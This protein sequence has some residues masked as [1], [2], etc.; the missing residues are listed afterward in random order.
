[1]KQDFGK[2]SLAAHKKLRG[3]I[4]VR[5]KAPVRNKKDL[6]LYYTPGVGTVASHVA[7][8][9]ED[10]GKMTSRGNM[11]AVVSDGSAVLG[12]GNI[13]PYGALPVMEG[14]AILFKTFAGIDAFPIVLNTQDP[15]RIVETV[16]ALE[17][18]FGAINLEDIAA[19][20]CFEIERRLKEEMNI[21]VMHDDQH[22]TAMV[23]LAGL[24]NA[25]KVRGG[26]KES[27]RIVVNG[28]GAAGLAITDLLLKY[29]F[30]HIVVSDSQGAIYRGR[31]GLN[32][33]KTRLAELTNT[34]CHIDQ[35]DPR[36]AVGDLGESL[37]GADVFIGVSRAGALKPAMVRLMNPKPIIF[38]MANPVPEIM[39]DE[40][41]K[42]GAYVVATG[43]SDFPNQINNSLGFPGIF[44]G[45][46]D[47][48]VKQ[49][50]DEMLV[51]AAVKLAALV[52]KPTPNMIIPDPFD[53]RVVKAVASAIR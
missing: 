45:A 38:A 43:R 35:N 41:K 10:A 12:L 17:P 25:L 13:G 42:A 2:L 15:D 52:K 4:E 53:K 51:K 31:E 48:G 47:N 3:K 18:S 39:P 34:V 14:K 30:K 28:A 8:R 32:G 40:A 24:I 50:T 16:K 29:G 37:K 22:G 1:M 46:L 11:V 20:Q 26:T 7:K 19:P 33:E 23:V 44:R 21:P 5:S 9:P 36:C 6:S 49:I 27:V